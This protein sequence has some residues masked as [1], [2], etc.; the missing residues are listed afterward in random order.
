MNNKIKVE[1]ESGLQRMFTIESGVIESATIDWYDDRDFLTF[2]IGIKYDDGCFQFFGGTT[3]LQKEKEPLC[4]TTQNLINDINSIFKVDSFENLKNKK[5]NAVIDK[6]TICG[7][8]NPE[9][10]EFFYLDIWRRDNFEY[11]KGLDVPKQN[12]IKTVLVKTVSRLDS[13]D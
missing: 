6:T 8:E 3:L 12:K 4:E 2:T 10:G 7:I 11:N 5:I 1:L 9:N 13:I